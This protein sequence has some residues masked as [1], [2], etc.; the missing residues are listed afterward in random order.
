MTVHRIVLLTSVPLLACGLALVSACS[1][2]SGG[3]GASGC[4]DNPFST[5]GI[6]FVKIDRATAC[7]R[8]VAALTSKAESLH[9]TLS[10]VPECPAVLDAFEANL[11]NAN[12]DVCIDSYS[13]G[14]I[15]NCE[16]RIATYSSC[17]DFATK[18]CEL[19]VIPPADGHKCPADGGVDTGNDARLLDTSAADSPP[20]AD[21]DAG[22]DASDGDAGDGG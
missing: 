11:K 4:P 14:A 5:N 2:N 15:A 7:A 12:P 10:P 20:D 22:A 16:C 8:Y 13:A 17:G 19:G 9:C 3:G 6:D 21:A 1:S 18:A